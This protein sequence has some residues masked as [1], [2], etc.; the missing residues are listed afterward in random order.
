MSRL[1]LAVF[2]AFS[3]LVAVGCTEVDPEV[4][5]PIHDFKLGYATVAAKNAVMAPGSRTA[6]AGELEAA[7]Q[8]SLEERLGKYRG[9]K[10]YHVAVAIEAYSLGAVGV[11]LLVSPKSA[12]VLR[13]T[14]WDDAAGVP[15][16]PRSHRLT[17]VEPAS[18]AMIVGSGIMHTRERQLQIVA[19]E[20]AKA[21]ENWLKSEESPIARA[22]AARNALAAREAGSAEQPG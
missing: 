8:A 16:E 19:D 4:P 11:P 21:I 20:S 5:S 15:L 22:V 10:F 13:A 18:P 1:A 6:E 17:V 7:L 3:A 12:F 9:T 14:V 2:I